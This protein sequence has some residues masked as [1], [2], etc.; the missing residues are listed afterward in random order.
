MNPGG[1]IMLTRYIPE[2]S[3]DLSRYL[4]WA[5]AEY[6]A[7]RDGSI[8]QYFAFRDREY[9]QKKAAEQPQEEPFPLPTSYTTV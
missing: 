6:A 9:Q 1:K 2:P 8:E 7:G 3:S 5:D 4:K